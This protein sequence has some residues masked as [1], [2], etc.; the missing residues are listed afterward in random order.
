MTQSDI[1]N[2]VLQRLYKLAEEVEALLPEV[3]ELDEVAAQTLSMTIL[4]LRQKIAEL[5]PTNDD[6]AETIL[7]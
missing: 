1:E 6:E 7:E 2:D 5:T 4:A 3:K